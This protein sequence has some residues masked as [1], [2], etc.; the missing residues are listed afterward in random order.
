MLAKLYR[1]SGDVKISD[2]TV[3]MRGR[4]LDFMYYLLKSYNLKKLSFG[5]GQPLIKASELN[6]L[7]LMFPTEEKESQKNR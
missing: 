3:Y 2:N 7:S 5:T 6:K 4:N 1:Y